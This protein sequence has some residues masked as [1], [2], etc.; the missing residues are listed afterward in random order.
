MTWLNTKTYRYWKTAWVKLLKSTSFSLMFGVPPGSLQS[1]SEI[2]GLPARPAFRKNIYAGA[3]AQ[4]T[5]PP[6]QWHATLSQYLTGIYGRDNGCLFQ[7]RAKK[8]FLKLSFW[9]HFSWTHDRRHVF[10]LIQTNPLKLE[11]F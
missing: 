10:L 11:T 9:Q 5:H 7:G 3:S 2:G 6:L 8:A 4:G 1:C